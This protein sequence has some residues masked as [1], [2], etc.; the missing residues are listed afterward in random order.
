MINSNG[1]TPTESKMLEVL[2]DGQPHRR[3]KL[4]DCL[5]DGLGNPHNIRRHLTAI[6]KRLRPQGMDVICQWIDRNYHYR[7]IK[8]LRSPGNEHP[9]PVFKD[10]ELPLSPQQLPTS[11]QQ[12]PPR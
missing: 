5:T 1:F 6:R 3:Q 8:L 12:L 11:P 2:Q 9:A 10:D 7:W 4:V